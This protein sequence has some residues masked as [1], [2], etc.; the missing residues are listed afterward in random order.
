[1]CHEKEKISVTPSYKKQGNTSILRD[2]HPSFFYTTQKPI[3]SS[4]HLFEA[5]NYIR[6]A[7][8]LSG[9]RSM[10]STRGGVR[11]RHSARTCTLATE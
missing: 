7:E 8:E 11:H 9:R 4:P 5:F 3:I 10:G 6:Q 2:D 1:M